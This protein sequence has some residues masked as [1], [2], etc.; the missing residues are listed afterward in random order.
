M[1]YDLSQV[2]FITT[3]NMLDPIIPALR[4][5]LEVIEL[6]GY[7]EDEKLHIARRFLVPKQ[8]AENGLEAEAAIFSDAALRTIVRE[9]THEAGVRG[10]EREIGQICR[11]VARRVAEGNART[12]R[13]S[14]ASLKRYLGAQ[15][16]FWGMA[17]ERDEIGVATGVARTEQGG[18]VLSVEV[19][20]MPGKGNL[21]LTGQLGEVMRE[22]VQAA[23]SYARSRA[24]E[25]G[26][27]LQEQEKQD[28]HVHVPAGAVPKDGPSAGITMATALISVFTGRPIDRQVAMTGEITLR[29][30]VLPVGGVKE[31]VLA[32]HRAGITTFVLPQKN[33]PDLDEV[34]VSVRRGLTFV[35][36]RD[37][38]D[39][40][41]TAFHG[42]HAERPVE[43]QAA[44]A[45]RA[46]QNR[47]AAVPTPAP[48]GRPRGVALPR[49]R[50]PVPPEPRPTSPLPN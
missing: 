47:P 22:S 44:R 1:P 46:R 12:V 43:R 25:L 34:P 32:A 13:L 35:F 48:A 2:L 3:A 27:P 14:P 7:T 20:L 19:T 23:L 31:K 37:M 49:L 11:K 42:W 30:R 36:A 38:R 28:I 39:V 33:R 26:L 50:T 18:D 15:K 10:L 4:D 9:Y 45:P 40:L 5:R 17:E 24:A 6:S 8:V 16:A 41:S 29:G 21:I